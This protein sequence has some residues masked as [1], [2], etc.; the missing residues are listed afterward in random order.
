MESFAGAQEA[1]YFF[2]SLS[3]WVWLLEIEKIENRLIHLMQI[4]EV[5]FDKLSLNIRIVMGISGY[6]RSTS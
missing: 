3:L 5:E 6:L 1:I 4:L 2:S